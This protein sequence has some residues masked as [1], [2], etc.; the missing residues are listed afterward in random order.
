MKSK[1]SILRSKHFFS[2]ILPLVEQKQNER[3]LNRFYELY[4]NHK[5][6]KN[7]FLRRHL[8]N[9]ILNGFDKYQLLRENSQSQKAALNN[10]WSTLC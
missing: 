2:G 5:M 4:S 3:I 10:N 8:V 7:D 6:Q 1:N 9:N